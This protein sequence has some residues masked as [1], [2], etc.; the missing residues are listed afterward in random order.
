MQWISKNPDPVS[1]FKD[2]W[3]SWIKDG[4]ERY[5]NITKEELLNHLKVANYFI[6]HFSKD[7][8]DFSNLIHDWLIGRALNELKED[9]L[10]IGDL[11]NK[12]GMTSYR[13]IY[14]FEVIQLFNQIFYKQPEP[15]QSLIEEIIK[16]VQDFFLKKINLDWPSSYIF[17]PVERLQLAVYC[18]RAGDPFSSI[19]QSWLSKTET[20]KI[21]A[22]AMEEKEDS[23]FLNHLD[24]EELTLIYLY[25]FE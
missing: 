24:P 21:L 16:W 19:A 1:D 13:E 8:P 9:C 14:Q 7:F 15:E 3:K 2:Q 17:D 12:T 25:A 5:L 18:I 11:S 6:Q 4:L 22:Q 20:R 10:R 23:Y